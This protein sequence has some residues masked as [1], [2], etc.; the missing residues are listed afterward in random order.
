[1]DHAKIQHFVDGL[2][3]DSIIP[4]LC[5]YVRIPNKSP[6]FDPEWE[7]HGYMDQAAEL[8][9]GWCREQ[10]VRGMTVDVVIVPKINEWNGRTNVEGEVRD[11]ACR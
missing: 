10:P 8:L 7:S 1:M 4:T 2:W 6:N 11:V 3:D 5:E 9:A